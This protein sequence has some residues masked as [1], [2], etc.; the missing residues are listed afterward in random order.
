MKAHLITKQFQSGPPSSPRLKE[1]GL[2][3]FKCGCDSAI[4]FHLKRLY[5]EYMPK[6]LFSTPE[7]SLQTTVFETTQNQGFTC[8]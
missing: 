6:I 2:F 3:P 5:F 8:V 4:S 7:V 1:F